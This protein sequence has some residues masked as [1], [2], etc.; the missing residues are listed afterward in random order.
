MNNFVNGFSKKNKLEKI[1]WII[2]N[3]FIITKRQKFLFKYLN[4]DAS[5]QSLHD[6]FIENTISNFYLPLQ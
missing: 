3:H 5:I 4:D 2:N 6:E 1:D